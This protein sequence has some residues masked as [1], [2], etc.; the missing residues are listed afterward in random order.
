[1]YWIFLIIFVISVLIPDIIRGGIFSLSETRVEEIFIFLMGAIAL[2]VFIRNE[3]IIFFQKKEKARDQ[4]KI[5][6]TVKD[7][8]ESYGYIGEVNRKMELLKNVA[9]GITER[10]VLSKSK[11][12]EIYQSIISAS[13]FLMK[14][15]S[16]VLRF[17]DID[18]L[19]TKKEIRSEQ[20]GETLKNSE[21]AQMDENTSVKKINNC[22]AVASGQKVKGVKSYII[23]CGYDSEEENDPK[24]MEILKVFV[25]QALF[26]YSYTHSKEI[27]ESS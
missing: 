14:S 20:K 23:I 5:D 24:N 11:E 15:D 19:K 17:V 22:L 1:M 4:K 12:N 16:T 25:S 10:S 3:R 7:L 6:Q 18:R 8:V 2:A 9:L 13:K 21:L 27:E 26:L